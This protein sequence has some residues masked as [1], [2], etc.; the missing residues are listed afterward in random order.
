MSAIDPASGTFHI[1]KR[2]PVALIVTIA[3][4][5]AAGIWWAASVQAAQEQA[6]V[7]AKRLETRVDRIEAAR[8]DLNTRV[9]RIEEKLVGQTDMLQ[10]I[11]RSVETRPSDVR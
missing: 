2:V 3:L 11:L 9:I 1:D 4:Q 8:D 7:D 10:R 6:L 5:T